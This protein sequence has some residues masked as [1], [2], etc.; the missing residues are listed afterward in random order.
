MTALVA[1][2]VE[3]TFSAVG[4]FFTGLPVRETREAGGQNLS[5]LIKTLGSGHVFWS[6]CIHRCTMLSLVETNTE[7]HVRSEKI[8]KRKRYFEDR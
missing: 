5:D 6:K 1:E 8:R 7:K 3:R 4:R 2:T